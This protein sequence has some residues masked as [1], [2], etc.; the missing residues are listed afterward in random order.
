MAAPAMRPKGPAVAMGM[1]PPVEVE[2][3]AE[4]EVE[5]A[6]LVAEESWDLV[7]VAV[8]V[9]L[10]ALLD[11]TPV[12]KPEEAPGVEAP[13]PLEALPDPVGM[14]GAEVTAE[15]AAE[16]ASEAP[17]V[18]SEAPEVT[19]GAEVSASVAVAEPDWAAAR[20]EKAATKIMEARMLMV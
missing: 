10:T 8:L 7:L 1:A 20:A 19:A 17:E 9:L 11:W 5:A 14:T 4:E 13:T 2:A 18:A 3:P 16:V 15:V 6:S 12:E